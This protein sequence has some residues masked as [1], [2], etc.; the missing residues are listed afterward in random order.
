MNGRDTYS[1]ELLSAFLDGEL[2][3]EELRY[4]EQRLKADPEYQRQLDAL[5]ALHDRLQGLRR[6][7]LSPDA[8][9]RILAA[10][11][12]RQIL[13]RSNGIS[14][15]Q[16][17]D[18]L[19]SAF[20]DGELSDEEREAVE[21]VLDQDEEQRGLVIEYQELQV[22]L[23]SLPKFRVS[24][25]FAD[26]V[27]QRIAAIDG[28][29]EAPVNADAPESQPVADSVRDGS[30]GTARGILWSAIAVAAALLL[31]FVF[32]NPSL[33]NALH[34][35]QPDGS[36]GVDEREAGNQPRPDHES[37]A[38]APD[39][40]PDSQDEIEHQVEQGQFELIPTVP[41]TDG[42]WQFVSSVGRNLGRKLVLVYEV[43]LTSEGNDQAAFANLLRR[44][45]I[46]F[47]QTMSVEREEQEDLLKHR[48]L[49]G[50]RVVTPAQKGM[51]RIDLYLVTTTGTVADSIYA[52]L[53]SRP[54]GISQFG[55]NLTTRDAQDRVLHR[56][57][58][59]KEV[60]ENAGQA[61][62][63]LTSLGILS[64]TARNVGAFGTLEWVDP[65]L[66]EPKLPLE[67]VEDESPDSEGV[68]DRQLPADDDENAPPRNEL[69]GD[70]EC[71][72][73]FVVRRWATVGEPPDG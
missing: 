43:S 21:A 69:T 53:M 71:Q 13:N 6:L 54:E 17:S 41:G 34:L 31:M 51:D 73:L 72:L 44:H 37:Y 32:S 30:A 42:Q 68:D 52:D 70:F 48:F 7:T 26:R 50:V 40:D 64:S 62:R 11:A 28:E 67:P 8:S 66:L 3:E 5:R 29:R 55:L 4:V 1:D 36:G 20:V 33:R 12:D 25:G 23:E 46:G 9:G 35:A 18:E 14:A 57:C 59:A 24:K 22:Q 58:N 63:L 15:G 16:L 2:T 27:L 38:V 56:L 10:I 45:G 60:R 19:L 61:V 49:D 39:T 65:T 47:Q